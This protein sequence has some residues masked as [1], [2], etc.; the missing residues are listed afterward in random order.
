[1]GREPTGSVGSE[2]E[3][4]AH[5]ARGLAMTEGTAAE[6]AAA[7][8]TRDEFLLRRAALSVPEAAY[9]ARSGEE[10]IREEIKAGRLASY[11]VGTW[12]RIP[13]ASLLRRIG[14]E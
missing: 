9:L 3:A 6:T 14:A 5:H 8:L 12:M 2:G 11:R 4:I 1:M 10:W 13:T 7:P